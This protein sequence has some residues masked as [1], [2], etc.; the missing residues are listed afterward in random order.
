MLK[1]TTPRS[2]AFYGVLAATALIAA[3]GS[4]AA[5][6]LTAYSPYVGYL[7]S[8]YSGPFGSDFSVFIGLMGRAK[9]NYQ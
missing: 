5:L 7:A 1:L 8:R 6:G 3:L 2:V 9:D 4:A